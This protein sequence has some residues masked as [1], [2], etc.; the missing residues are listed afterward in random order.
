MN[1]VNQ[2][3]LCKGCSASVWVSIDESY[4]KLKKVLVDET[5]AVSKEVY[6]QRLNICKS[7][8]SLEYGTTCSHCGCLVHARALAK[9]SYCPFPGQKKW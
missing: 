1:A 5:Q 9:N 7:C 6:L 4:D 2:D 8:P 3:N